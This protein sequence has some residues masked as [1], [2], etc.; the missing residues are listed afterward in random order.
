MKLTWFS[1]SVT[2]VEQE[3]Q[4][5][6][7]ANGTIHHAPEGEAID[8]NEFV[9]DLSKLSPEQIWRLNNWEDAIQPHTDEGGDAYY[10]GDAYEPINPVCARKWKIE[11]VAM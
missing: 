11:Y 5:V 7:A 3:L 1:K 8:D 10:I 4:D 9:P 2:P 6:E